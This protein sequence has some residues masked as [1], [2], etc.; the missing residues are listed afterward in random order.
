MGRCGGFDADEAGPVRRRAAANSGALLLGRL[1]AGAG[2]IRVRQRGGDRAGEMRI[3]RLLRHRRVTVGESFGTAAAHTAGLLA[4]R[5]GLAIQHTTSLRDDRAGHRLTLHP[6]IAVDATKLALLG[7]LHGRMLVQR[8]GQAA[9]LRSAGAAALT[10][11]A[12]REGDIFEHV[13]L[14]P[15]R[16]HR[17][18]RAAQ[19]RALAEAGTLFTGLAGLA[20]LGRMAITLPAA[21]AARQRWRCGAAA[22]ASAGPP[23]ALAKPPSGWRRASR[24]PRSR[25]PR[26]I[27]PPRRPTGGGSPAMPSPASTMPAGAA[28]A[29]APARPSSRCSAR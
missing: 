1:V 5:H 22:S 8:G 17:L 24:S 18:V 4:G 14:R 11:I 20:E 13:A 12:D 6:M 27:R 2:A 3:S 19:D 28:A 16:V 7:L 29:T 15:E 9:G 21:P 25:C 23:A 10:A 26:S